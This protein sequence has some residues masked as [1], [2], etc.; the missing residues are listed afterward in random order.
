V[1]ERSKEQCGAEGRSTG[2]G[3]RAW[4]LQLKIFPPAADGKSCVLVHFPQTLDFK[5]LEKFRIWHLW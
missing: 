5:L 4:E 1:W 2:G 3:S